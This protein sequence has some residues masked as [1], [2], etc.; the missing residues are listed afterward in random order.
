MLRWNSVLLVLLLG[1]LAVP[2]VFAAYA[3]GFAVL[4]AALYG[5]V[6]M[7]GVRDEKRERV[8][9]L[10]VL[11]VGVALVAPWVEGLRRTLF[12]PQH[13]PFAIAAGL[14]LAGLLMLPTVSRMISTRPEK[15]PRR[16]ATPR[17]ARIV[18]TP[19][20]TRELTADGDDDL[21]LLP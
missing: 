17:R 18:E 14:G 13:T 15:A 3:K 21:G 11:C 7:L 2:G 1:F 8:A 4:S 20:D 5:L 9:Q 10:F 19:R 16:T 12:Q 6:T